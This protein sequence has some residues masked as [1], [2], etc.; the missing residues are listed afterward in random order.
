M[1]A[2]ALPSVVF[3]VFERQRTRPAA[4]HD[5]IDADV[6]EHDGG[7]I[8]VAPSRWSVVHIPVRKGTA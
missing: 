1:A 3:P 2:S 6:E 4:D 8:D 7:E 5:Q